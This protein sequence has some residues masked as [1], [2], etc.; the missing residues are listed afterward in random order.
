MVSG[1][2]GWLGIEVR[3]LRLGAHTYDG[4]AGQGVEGAVWQLEAGEFLDAE[5]DTRIAQRRRR[6]RGIRADMEAEYVRDGQ[7][8]PRN[9]VA[10][11]GRVGFGQGDGMVEQAA[12]GADLVDRQRRG[13]SIGV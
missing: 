7:P 10:R 4:V 9:G 2:R 1:T 11:L 12:V 5:R 3:V 13:R 8:L 6:S